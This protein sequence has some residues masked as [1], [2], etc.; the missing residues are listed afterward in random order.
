MYRVG[1]DLGGTNIEVG[2]IDEKYNIISRAS[3]KTAMPR[4]ADAIVSDMADAVFEAI[5]SAGLDISD[6]CSAG[7][8]SP[9]SVDSKNGIVRFSANLNFNNTPLAD[10]LKQKTGLEFRL[11]NDANAAALGEFL[12]GSGNGARDFMMITLG[13]GIGG[14]IVVG[15]KVVEGVNGAGGEVGHIVIDM[16]GEMCNCGRRGCFEAYGSVTALIRQTKYAIE[17]NPGSIMGKAEKIDGRTAFDAAKLGDS[18]ALEVVDRYTTYL[19][20]GLGNLINTLQPEI[21]AIGGGISREGEFLLA[22]IREKV[23]GES[24]CKNL[25]VVPKIC[26]AKLFGDAGIIGAAFLG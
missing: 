15:G 17:K 13:T 18:A 21:I 7:V 14:G 1:I 12:A 16:N 23:K 4:S 19:A 22:P 26:A 6:I 5:N 25:S 8:G 20:I 11:G 3:R 9:G 24:F 2:V 10:M